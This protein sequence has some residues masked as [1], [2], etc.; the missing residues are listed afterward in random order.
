MAGR[1]LQDGLAAR[2]FERFVAFFS[3]NDL[4]P[5]QLN[6]LVLPGSCRVSRP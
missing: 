4:Q 5:S 2:G 3:M 6:K 1:A